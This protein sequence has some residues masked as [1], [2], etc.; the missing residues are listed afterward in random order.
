MNGES[1]RTLIETGQGGKQT[2]FSEHD[3][4][5][6]V[7][8]SSVQRLLGT[9]AEGSNLAV[10]RTDDHRLVQFA[11]ALP[12][13]VFDETAAGDLRDVA[14]LPNGQA[15]CLDLSRKMLCHIMTKP[16]ST[17]ATTMV[18]DGGVKNGPG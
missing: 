1:L 18:I 3:F 14:S 10:L 4:G 8:P 12:Q 11:E 7:Q 9:S 16:E 13:L 6:P 15:I 2:T 5:D 17:F